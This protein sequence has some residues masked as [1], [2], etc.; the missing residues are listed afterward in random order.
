VLLVVGV[1]L[2]AL[3]AG[4]LAF[5]PAGES[6]VRRAAIGAPAPGF[7]TFDL[8]NERVRLG[9][10]DEPVLLNFWASWCVPCRDEFPM[11]AR[12][13]GQGVQVLGVIFNDTAAEARQFMRSQRADWPGLLDPQG[14]IAEAYDVHAR[15]GIPVTFAIDA[16]GIVRA[17]HLGPLSQADLDALLRLIHP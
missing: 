3:V 7:T 4:I 15:P 12:V 8:D 2:V 1:A 13:H 5:R 16:A 10:V 14:R 6:S 9:D 11:L 17:K